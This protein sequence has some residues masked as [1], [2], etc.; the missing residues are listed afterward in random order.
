[1]HVSLN[2]SFKQQ[3]CYKALCAMVSSISA[4]SSSMS[5]KHVAVPTEED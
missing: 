4:Q 2:P 3:W 1:M 5:K